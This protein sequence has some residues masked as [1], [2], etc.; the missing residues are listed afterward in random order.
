M[1]LRLLPVFCLFFLLPA[2]VQAETQWILNRGQAEVPV[3]VGQGNLQQHLGL[4]QILPS[5]TDLTVTIPMKPEDAFSAEEKPF[6]AM[7]YRMKTSQKIGGIFFTTDSLKSLSDQ[8]Y[9][10]FPIVG[11]GQ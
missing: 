3:I 10:P 4:T 7:R 5:G 2:A 8:S 11:D 1:R 6:F 9:S